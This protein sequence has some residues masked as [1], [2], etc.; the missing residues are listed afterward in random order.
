MTVSVFWNS[1]LGFL[2][3]RTWPVP[4]QPCHQRLVQWQHSE[5][6][7]TKTFG[8]LGAAGGRVGSLAGVRVCCGCWV[9]LVA[10]LRA[11]DGTVST[12]PLGG[13]DIS[14]DQA[15]QPRPSP[16]WGNVAQGFCFGCVSDVA[17]S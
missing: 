10:G 14:K 2:G 8:D 3:F 15:R 4:S 12:Q 9:Q 11:C 16:G 7:G 6:C 5:P 17:Q 1:G 13:V